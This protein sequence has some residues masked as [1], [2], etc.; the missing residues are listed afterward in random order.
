MADT[1]FQRYSQYYDLLYRDKEYQAEV[2]YI[3]Q[4]LRSVARRRAVCWNSAPGQVATANCLL[5]RA[6][7]FSESNVAEIWSRKHSA[8]VRL[9]HRTTEGLIVAKGTSKR[10]TCVRSLMQS[11]LSFT[12]S[13]TRPAMPI[14]SRRL[15]MLH[16]I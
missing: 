13:V 9:V 1:V 10:S 8:K 14:S 16:D 2:D 15:G 6:S 7:M 4:T 5:H 3:V 12:L 11:F